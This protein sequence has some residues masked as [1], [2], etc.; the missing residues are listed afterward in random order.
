MVGYSVSRNNERLC[1]AGV[2]DVGVLTACVT[3][4]GHSPAKL[5]RW[6]AEGISD[7]APMELTLHVGGLKSDDGSPS[8]HMR[9]IDVGLQVGDEITIHVIDTLRVDT[10]DTEHRDDP[11]KDLDAKKT[12]VRKL[13]GELGWELREP[14]NEGD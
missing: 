2:G 12:Y 5:A 1:I 14:C 4:A 9:W 13:A 10:A 3:W 8:V 7:Q 6:A 11:V